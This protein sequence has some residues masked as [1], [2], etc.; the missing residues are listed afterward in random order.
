MI[1]NFTCFITRHTSRGY[2][3]LY[4]YQVQYVIFRLWLSTFL[5]NFSYGRRLMEITCF[6]QLTSS[7]NDVGLLWSNHFLCLKLWPIYKH[8]L[9]S[10]TYNVEYEHK[11]ELFYELA[12][13][14]RI[15]PLIPLPFVLGAMR[16]HSCSHLDAYIGRVATPTLEVDTCPPSQGK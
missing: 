4:F 15:P 8:D 10:H 1:I 6:H 2:H 5:W 13:S 12:T 3:T 14:K 7:G 11:G 16:G 9:Q